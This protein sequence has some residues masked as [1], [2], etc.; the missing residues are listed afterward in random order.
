MIRLALCLVPL[1]PTAA[2]AHT[3]LVAHAHPHGWEITFAVV[4]LAAFGIVWA[5]RP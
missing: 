5:R 3:G 2:H 4:A 1:V